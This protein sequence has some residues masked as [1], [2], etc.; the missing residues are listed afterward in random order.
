EA[1]PI[2]NETEAQI[3]RWGPHRASAAFPVAN[4]IRH[5]GAVETFHDAHA[6]IVD[7]ALYA[8]SVSRND[9]A[10][11]ASRRPFPDVSRRVGDTLR[12]HA[13]RT[14]S[15]WGWI[16]FAVESRLRSV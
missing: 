1:R 10:D 14:T 8:C 5:V 2:T 12:V 11:V 16:G 9:S 4:E 13:E 15:S 7:R 6:A 3:V